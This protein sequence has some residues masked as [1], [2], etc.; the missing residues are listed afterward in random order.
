MQIYDENFK[1]IVAG[2]WVALGLSLCGG[3]SMGVGFLFSPAGIVPLIIGLERVF[4][5]CE[6]QDYS[7]F[8]IFMGTAC[9]T[10][11]VAVF[12]SFAYFGLIASDTSV[13]ERNELKKHKV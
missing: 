1:L 7:F 10:F 8:P 3:C 13:K 11:V 6:T 9:T 4:K 2:F 12:H 5:G